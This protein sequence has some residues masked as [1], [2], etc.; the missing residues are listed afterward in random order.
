MSHLQL[1][2]FT[3]WKLRPEFLSH[4][5]SSPSAEELPAE[6]DWLVY[7]YNPSIIFLADW[8]NELEFEL[9]MAIV[10][11]CAKDKP[12]ALGKGLSSLQSLPASA[13]ILSF[14]AEQ[15]AQ[16]APEYT[17]RGVYQHQGHTL[18]IAYSLNQLLSDPAY[19]KDLWKTWQTLV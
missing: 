7:Q 3:S 12:Y 1:M 4:T 2:G 15:T 14:G 19:K 17:S 10:K 18:Y 16:I 13:I 11:A 5:G 6:A 9:L 8:A